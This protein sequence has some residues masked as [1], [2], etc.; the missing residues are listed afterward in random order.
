MAGFLDARPAGPCPRCLSPLEYLPAVCRLD[1]ERPLSM[2]ER[3][4]LS[5]LDAAGADVPICSAC[6]YWYL[7]PLPLAY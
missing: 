7:F 4:A 2:L 6:G 1:D 3:A 5:A